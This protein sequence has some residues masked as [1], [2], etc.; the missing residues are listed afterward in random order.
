[1]L[2]NIM[3]TLLLI[4]IIIIIIFYLKRLILKL[5]KVSFNKSFSKIIKF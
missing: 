4:I 2:Y 5:S 3:Q 1:M